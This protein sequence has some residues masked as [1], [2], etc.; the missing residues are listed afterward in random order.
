MKHILDRSSLPLIGIAVI[1]L[2]AIAALMVVMSSDPVSDAVKSDR[3]IS[4]LVVFEEEGEPVA[5]E[6]FFFYPSTG[7]GAVLDIPGNTGLILKSLN[8][9]DRIDRVYAKGRPQTYARE[10]A[11]LLQTELPLWLVF[12]EKGMKKTA[13]FLEG[14]EMFIPTEIDQPGPPR[15]LLPQGTSLL[16]GDKLLQFA[17][18]APADEDDATAAARR[19]RLFQ[20]FLR[21]MARKSDWLTRPEVFPAWRESIRTNLG[22]EGLHQFVRGLAGIDIDHLLMQ[23]ITGTRR[24]VDKQTLLFP[25]YDGDLVRDIVKQTL[26][27]LMATG[28]GNTE[29]HTVEILNG[30]TVKGLAAKAAEILGSFGYDVISVGNA[31]KTDFDSTQIVSRSPDSRAAKALGGVLQCKNIGPDDGSLG[32]SDAEFTIVLGA[33]FNGRYVIGNKP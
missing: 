27:A 19:Q 8:K 32:S 31:D 23:R 16:D 15:I 21:A 11:S 5:T 22:V 30:T 14:V 3:I 9:V 29:I 24:I 26:N 7:K 4:L 6:V 25:H 1:A 18:W 17:S 20:S 12:D 13:D 33:D 2:G 10:I 28:S